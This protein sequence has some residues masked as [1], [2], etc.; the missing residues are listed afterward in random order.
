MRGIYSNRDYNNFTG[1]AF[2]KYVDYEFVI[3]QSL[4]YIKHKKA[5]EQPLSSKVL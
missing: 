4:I 5:N 2:Y 3:E 1:I